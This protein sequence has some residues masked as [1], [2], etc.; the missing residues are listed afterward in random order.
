MSQ[1]TRLQRGELRYNEPL[2]GYTTWRVGGPADQL[3]S[4]VDV[5]DLAAF[6]ARL[7]SNEPLLWLGL[8]SNLLVRDGGFRGTVIALHGALAEIVRLSGARVQAGA[9]ATCARLARILVRQQLTGGEFLGGIPGTLGG[10]LATNAGAFGGH[11][12]ELVEEV[13]TIDRLGRLRTR[14][15]ADYQ[16][17][18]REVKPAMIHDE[19][20]FIAAMLHLQPAADDAGAERIRTLLERRSRTQPIGMASAGST[21]R[22]PEGD[23]A[24]R[25]IEASGLK[26][27]REGGA[28][29][30][31]M[32][33]NFIIN[34]GNATAADIETLINRIQS[35]VEELHG[36]RLI[37][38]VNM[39]GD[40]L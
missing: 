28:C 25:L 11:I 9:G 26:G 40:S 30:S 1:E 17:S 38:E 39:V 20:W 12:W 16:I 15:P 24:A 32:H 21:F 8:G 5:A 19:E 27:L 2:S 35:R 29:V 18:Y 37:P 36:V 6:M 22:N 23:Y 4:P 14:T 33:A 3:Y 13:T 34:T 7:P 10:A 31:L